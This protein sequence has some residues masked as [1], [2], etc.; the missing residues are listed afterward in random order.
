MPAAQPAPASTPKDP[1]GHNR[2]ASAAV[3]PSVFVYLPAAQLLLHVEEE[4]AVDQV[5]LLQFRHALDAA[6]GE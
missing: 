5:P 6:A 2:Q 1:T 4:P 3:A